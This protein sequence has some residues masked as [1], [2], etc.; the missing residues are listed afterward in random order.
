[1]VTPNIHVS[2][3]S[4]IVETKIPTGLEKSGLK[5]KI[6][7][8]GKRMLSMMLVGCDKIIFPPL[9]IKLGLMKRFVKALDKNG[10]CFAYIREKMPHLS[11]QKIKAGIFNGP[12]ITQIIKDSAFT[13]SMN[14]IEKKGWASFVEVVQQF[15][16]NHKAETY[17][18]LVN[19][20]LNCFQ[21]LGCNMSIKVHYLHSHLDRFP[22]NL[23][24]TSEE[25]G[26]RFHQDIKTMEDR[27]QGR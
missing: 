4:G 14:E 7:M 16:G 3:A 5:E 24:D 27:Y 19:E 6:W 11:T 15:L 12:Q 1:M 21:S 8:S 25:Q 10:S 26:E 17:V 22:E 9:H 18:E 23:G 2:C 20:M 13:N